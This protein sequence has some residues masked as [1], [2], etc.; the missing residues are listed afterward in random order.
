[1]DSEI[2][3]ALASTHC[4]ACLEQPLSNRLKKKIIPN[5]LLPVN[6]KRGFVFIHN[7]SISITIAFKS[8]LSLSCLMLE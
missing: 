7:S 1:M 5:G 8:D 2:E 4:S 3:T 6:Y